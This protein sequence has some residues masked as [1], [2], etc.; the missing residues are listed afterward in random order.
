MPLAEKMTY[1]VHFSENDWRLYC[2]IRKD[3]A[4]IRNRTNKNVVTMDKYSQ[5]NCRMH[6]M[7]LLKIN[8]RK[9]LY[10]KYGQVRWKIY[11]QYTDSTRTYY[12]ALE[13]CKKYDTYV[14]L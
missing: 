2:F 10:K 11:K 13:L 1:C 6:G 4:K 12:A 3:D 9:L 14:K 5:R 8:G 7:V